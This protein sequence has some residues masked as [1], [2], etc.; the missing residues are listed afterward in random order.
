[1]LSRAHS[2]IRGKTGGQKGFTLAEIIV[3]IGVFAIGVMSIAGLFTSIQ[4]TQRGSI[5]LD[6]ASEAARAQIEKIRSTQATSI[7]SG[8]TINFT[9]S[10][11]SSLPAGSTGTVQVKTPTNAPK[12]L[13]LEVTVTYPVG[14]IQKQVVMNAYVDI[15]GSS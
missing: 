5:Y 6:A 10:L 7:T 8:Q 12:A 11:P 2:N 4:S 15:P 13:E 1:M 3:V 14:S 9:S